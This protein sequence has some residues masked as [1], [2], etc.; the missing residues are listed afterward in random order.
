MSAGAGEGGDAAPPGHTGERGTAIATA[1][2]PATPMDAP[3]PAGI[4]T[5]ARDATRDTLLALLPGLLLT[6]VLFG[7]GALANLAAIAAV[8]YA[9][10]TASR[11]FA[12]PGHR[13]HVPWIGAIVLALALPPACPAWL[14]ALCALVMCAAGGAFGTVRL[15]FNAAM[16]AAAFAF[17]LLPGA[18]SAWPAQPVGLADWG[19][20][21]QQAASAAPTRAARAAAVGDATTGTSVIDGSTGATAL[22]AMAQRAPL[23]ISEVRAASPAFGSLGA[24]GGEWIAAAWLAG[25]LWLMHRGVIGWQAP[26]GCVA[27]VLLAAALLYDG[28]G[29]SGGAPPL[30]HLFAGGTLLVACFVL[31]EP[32]SGPRTPGGRVVCGLCAGVLICGLRDAAGG[33]D[34]A[35]VAVLLVNALGPACDALASRLR[36]PAKARTA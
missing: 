26:L 32:G 6:T 5:R 8:G 31:T 9:V 4:P 16:V 20:Q 12:K 33:A 11:A 7:P 14:P 2:T 34:R 13:E 21:L 25:G 35:A 27:G 19:T 1:A 24:A 17:I 36:R 10:R 28:D 3:T 18:L 22:V 30:L 29:T 15:P 23:T